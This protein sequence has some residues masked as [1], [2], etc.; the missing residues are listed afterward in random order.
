MPLP[1]V[2]MPLSS[3]T[4]ANNHGSSCTTS[5]PEQ[6]VVDKQFH[7]RTLIILHGILRGASDHKLFAVPVRIHIA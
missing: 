6:R 1:E 3:K 4:L 2:L 7:D 5:R